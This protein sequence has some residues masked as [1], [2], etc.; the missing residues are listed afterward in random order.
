ERP[1]KKATNGRIEGINLDD[2]RRVKEAVGVPVLVTGGFQTRSVVEAAIGSGACDGVTIGR[3]LI[4]NPNLV[5]LWQAGRDRPERPCT[6]SNKCL[7][8]QLEN[9]LGCYDASRFDSHE[10]MVREILSVYDPP[11]FA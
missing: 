8:N 9:P 6:Y 2:S 11:P 7:I 1:A 5:Q 4:A 10:E 3:P